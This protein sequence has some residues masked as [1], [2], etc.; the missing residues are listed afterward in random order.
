MAKMTK[1]EKVF[2]T[3]YQRG[4]SCMA[5]DTCEQCMTA[6]LYSDTNTPCED[7]LENNLPYKYREFYKMGIY[8]DR[9]GGCS[10]HIESTIFEAWIKLDNGGVIGLPF[11]CDD[12]FRARKL[13]ER[14]AAVFDG[15]VVQV[16]NIGKL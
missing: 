2:K 12:E 8:Y 3:P 7:D 13:A 11:P 9:F 14:V 1:T 4:F 10:N 5:A 6:A 16:S 15:D